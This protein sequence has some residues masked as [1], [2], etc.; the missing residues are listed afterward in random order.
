GDEVVHF[1]A[2]ERRGPG[3]DGGGIRRPAA[4]GTREGER[5][6]KGYSGQGPPADHPAGREY[7]RRRHPRAHEQPGVQGDHGLRCLHGPQQQRRSEGREKAP[8]EDR[9][10]DPVV[11]RHTRG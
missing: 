7:P 8:E 5:V 4:L 1:A 6:R 2:E 3:G 9:T 10:V 11:R